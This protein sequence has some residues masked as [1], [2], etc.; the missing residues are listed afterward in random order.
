MTD[1]ASIR[2]LL[3][4][5][6]HELAAYGVKS[7]RVF[8]SVARGEATEASDV[9]VLVE[10]DGPATFRAFMGLKLLLQDLLGGDVDLVT[11][12]ALRAEYRDE[13]LR[14]AVAIA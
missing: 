3:G 6:R 12:R 10:F 5:H 14:E 1:L 11:T 7:L 8:G 2:Q 13:V 9:D 4:T